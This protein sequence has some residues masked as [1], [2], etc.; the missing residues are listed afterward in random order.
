METMPKH[1]HKMISGAIEETLPD[2]HDVNRGSA[3]KRY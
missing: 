3:V 2:G 1:A